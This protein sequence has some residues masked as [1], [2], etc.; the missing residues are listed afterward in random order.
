MAMSSMPA[1]PK[2]K[3]PSA[4][5]SAIILANESADAKG[6]LPP[7]SCQEQGATQVTCTA[8]AFGISGVIFK[9]YPSLTA[10]YAAYVAKA[11]SLNSGHFQANFQD[12]GLQQTYGEVGWN[13]QFWHPRTYTVAQ[14]SS[15]MVTDA[16]AAGR[17][18]CNFNNGQENMVWTQNDGHLLAYVYGPVHEDVWNWFVAV[19]HNIGFAGSPMHM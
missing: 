7:S 9:T 8:P 13:H 14:M 19:H 5:M 11:E 1:K 4:L 10:L 17:V 3:P 15:G 16:Q 6:A 12:C 18:F 2:V